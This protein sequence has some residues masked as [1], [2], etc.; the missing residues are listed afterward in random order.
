MKHLQYFKMSKVT[1][2]TQKMGCFEYVTRL[3]PNDTRAHHRRSPLDGTKGT[4][5][6][7]RKH[8]PHTGHPKE[9]DTGGGG[10]YN[11]RE[12]KITA[13]AYVIV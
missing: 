9:G 8:H 11:F 7:G 1:C 12:N 6:A 4:A 2:V 5:P 13:A 3:Y 10:I